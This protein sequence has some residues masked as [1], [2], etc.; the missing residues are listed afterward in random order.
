MNIEMGYEPYGEALMTGLQMH[1]D[2]QVLPDGDWIHHVRR[3]T[4]R[5]NFFVYYHKGTGMFVWAMWIYSPS[6]RDKPVC[7]ELETMDKPPDRGGWIPDR[8][9]QLRL[10]PIEMEKE[11]REKALKD[12]A[13]AR[14]SKRHDDLER[15]EDTEKWLRG[16][17]MEDAAIGLSSS[18]LHYEE[19]EL[20]EELK[21]MAKGKIITRG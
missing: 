12:Q 17:G 10:V 9:V 6:E 14:E 5:D 16:K 3:I 7:M 13:S 19:S 18:P 8:F 11:Q 4:G 2:C 15:R 1:E 20:A 21:S